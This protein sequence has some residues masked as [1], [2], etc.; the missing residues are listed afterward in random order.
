MSGRETLYRAASLSAVVALQPAVATAAGVCDAIPAGA[1]VEVRAEG[2]RSGDWRSFVSK[3]RREARLKNSVVRGRRQ[4]CDAAAW[5]G[6]GN[7]A[8]RHSFVVCARV[9]PTPD[10]ALAAYGPLR[11]TSEWRMACGNP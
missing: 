11:A 1:L 4:S 8:V 5:F 3:V 2:R 10:R 9:I 7:E 6:S